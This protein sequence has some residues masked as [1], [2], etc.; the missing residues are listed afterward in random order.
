MIFRGFNEIKKF[1]GY[2]YFGLGNVVLV[3]K[4]VM[5][6]YGICFFYEIIRKYSD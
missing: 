1:Y 6:L 3:I 5:K 2:Y 4:M